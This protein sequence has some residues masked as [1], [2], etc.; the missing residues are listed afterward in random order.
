MTTIEHQPPPSTGYRRV[1]AVRRWA[2]RIGA[3]ALVGIGIAHTAVN[4]Y[5]YLTHRDGTLALFLAFGLGVS[6][7]AFALAAVAWRYGRPAGQPGTG[8]AA[9][10]L[11]AVAAVLLCITAAQVLRNDPSVVWLPLGPGPWSVL[12][13]PVLVLA[14]CCPRRRA[15]A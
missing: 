1:A 8:T 10:I 13:G 9:R 5:S 15:R 3:V 12:G 4:G 11:V 6:V 14:A 2:S 7:L